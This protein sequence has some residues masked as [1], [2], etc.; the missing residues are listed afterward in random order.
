[1]VVVLDDLLGLLH[2]PLGSGIVTGDDLL[3][4]MPLDDRWSLAAPLVTVVSS[5]EEL[6]T[7]GF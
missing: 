7:A 3:Q 4:Q 5:A 2:L 1:M 6:T